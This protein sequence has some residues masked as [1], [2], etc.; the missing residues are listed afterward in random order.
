MFF[1]GSSDTQVPY[2]KATLFGIGFYG[3]KSLTKEFEKQSWPYWFYDIEY[4]THAIAGLPMHENHTEILTFLKEYVEK[5]RPLSIHTYV[6][7][8]ELPVRET[9][10]KVKDYLEANYSK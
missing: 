4:H 6:R 10:F 3:P 1:H 9:K 8:G 2:D 5:Q 7:N